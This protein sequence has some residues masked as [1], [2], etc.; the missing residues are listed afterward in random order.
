MQDTANDEIDLIEF[1]ETLW[2]AK[3][4]I[5]TITACFSVI[6]VAVALLLPTSF[7][8]KLRITALTKQQMATYQ[9]LNNTPGISAPIYAG[10]VLI[11]QTGVVLSEEMFAAFES[12]MR[13]GRIFGAAHQNLDPAIKTFDGT[14]EELVQTLAKIGQAYT[15]ALDKG[16]EDAGTLTF[17]TDNRELALAI[18]EM[19]LSSA[20]DEIRTDNLAAI[21]DL[22]RSIET[23]LAF[24]LD[25]VT[26]QIDNA[27]ANYEIETIARR[28][29]LKEQAAIARQ[30]GNANGAAIASGS[31]GI[32]VAVE[33][34]Q[35][36]YIRGYKALEKEIALIDA[37]GKGADAYPY[38]GN[39][40]SLSARKRALESDKR[41]QR[42][43]TGLAQTPLADTERFEA[44]NYD[45]ETVVFDATSPKLLIVILATL[46]GG[47][48]AV[49]FVL[50]RSALVAR[51]ASGVN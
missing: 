35:P 47:L 34:K 11:G 30:L 12:K 29:L 36:L 3:W 43:E 2:D 17:K 39:Y 48:I 27:L 7:E 42:I 10:S 33:Q 25:E 18:I 21:A 37:R 22:S 40:A 38:V 45:L 44:A 13:Q 51:Q 41:L 49:I 19:A 5:T 20:T 15:F 23:S 4:L 26:T 46:M 32:N 28:A 24:E 14:A 8:G 1:I 31:S 9:T 50:I 6:S 16:A